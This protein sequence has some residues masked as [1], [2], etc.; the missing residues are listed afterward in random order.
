MSDFLQ[1]MA[2]LSAERAA[3]VGTIPGSALDKPVVPLQLDSFDI[4]A[5]IKNRS[6]AEGQLSRK[7]VRCPNRARKT[8]PYPYEKV[9]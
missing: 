3:A 8:Y 4:I 5:E 7:A 9:I 2:E 6:P 1:T